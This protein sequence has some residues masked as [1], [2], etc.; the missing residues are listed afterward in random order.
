M[1]FF[2]NDHIFK[3]DWNTVVSAFWLK[4]PNP[5]QPHVMRIDTID[6]VVDRE[7]R[8]Y[9][10][11]RLLSLHYSIP[12]WL[13]A[14]PSTGYGLEE[15]VCDL[16]SKTLTLKSRNLTFSS[17]F[18]VEETCEYRPHPDHAEHWTLYTQKASY[19]ISGLGY[20][21]QMLEKAVV[22][23]AGE[24][25]KKGLEAMQAVIHRL[26][27]SDWRKT[28]TDTMHNL[29]QKWIEGKEKVG[30]TVL[31]AKH[32][33]EGTVC[34]SAGLPPEENLEKRK[35]DISPPAADEPAKLRRKNPAGG[36]SPAS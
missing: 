20:L 34:R 4:Y 5:L 18:Q 9:R 32:K 33:V 21:S 6:R 12:S 8:Q 27:A 1:R 17:F 22:Q 36:D 16:S 3:H 30:K 19:K 14:I 10:A 25:A 15:T 26:E 28:Y 29:G 11:L 13:H 35:K 2:N 31:D 7:N 24:K 23:A